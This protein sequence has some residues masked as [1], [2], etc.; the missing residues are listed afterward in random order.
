MKLRTWVLAAGGLLL[1][2]GLVYS[3]YWLAQPTSEELAERNR[4]AAQADSLRQV[5]LD[6]DGL[7]V[8]FQR[9]VFDFTEQSQ[10]DEFVKDSM[11]NVA[12]ALR[13]E[14]ARLKRDNETLVAGYAE[15]RDR[16]DGDLGDISVS[17]TLVSASISGRKDYEDGYVSA[18]GDVMVRTVDDPPTGRATLDFEVGMSPAVS[19]S[20]DES[21]L[22]QCDLSYGD[23]PIVV[24]DLKC[25]N[26]LE[27]DLPVRQSFW[28]LAPSLTFG[29]VTLVAA[30]SILAAITILN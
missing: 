17:D 4:Q 19:V 29:G 30:V 22:A 21:G 15:L 8:S 11:H 2:A 12:N 5:K 13:S 14:N 6:R 7:R 16:L 27:P 25:V 18:S 1:S 28:D 26:N 10:V 20:R 3:G 23:M 9:A 24:T